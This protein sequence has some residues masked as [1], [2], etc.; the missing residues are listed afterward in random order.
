LR[1]PRNSF[2]LSLA[3]VGLAVV[4]CSSFAHG[5]ASVNPLVPPPPHAKP[6]HLKHVLVIGQTK[7]FEHDSISAAMDAIFQMGKQSGLW[8]TQ[9]P[10]PSW[11]ATRA[12]AH[13]AL[14]GSAPKRSRMPA[15]SRK[16]AR[17][18]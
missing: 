6:I 7:G 9:T 18:R 13:A 11:A 1:T 17:C 16:I 2:C 10:S 3:L 15:C 8:D 12:T 5:Q 14:V 4:L